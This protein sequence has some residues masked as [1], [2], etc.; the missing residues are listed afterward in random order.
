MKSLSLIIL[1]VFIAGCAEQFTAKTKV[2]VIKGADSYSYESDKNQDIEYNPE[3]GKLHVRAVTP[4]SVVA[5]T[6]QSQQRLN[7][8]MDALL[9][10]MLKAAV[11][12]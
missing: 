9:G 4:D 10:I 11:A 7:E 8:K 3:T 6:L 5:A 1:A 12:P 2:S